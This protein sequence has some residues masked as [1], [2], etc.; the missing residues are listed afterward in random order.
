MD[1]AEIV[2]SG[3]RRAGLSADDRRIAVLNTA[4]E[5]EN[6]VFG[7]WQEAECGPGG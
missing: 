5:A 3:F 2:M 1:G 7:C 6:G 4:F